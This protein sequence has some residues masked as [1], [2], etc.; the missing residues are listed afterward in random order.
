MGF[1]NGENHAYNIRRAVA[2]LCH[3]MFV[4]IVLDR[5]YEAD[6]A[7]VLIWILSEYVCILSHPVVVRVV[8]RGCR[9]VYRHRDS[10]LF[11]KIW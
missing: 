9:P 3:I 8:C 7:S 11:Y 10:S 4:R 2:L 1:L 6:Y 5:L